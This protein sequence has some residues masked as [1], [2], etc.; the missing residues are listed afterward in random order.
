MSR[1]QRILVAGATR[2]FGE[3]LALAA[4]TAGLPVRALVRNPARAPGALTAAGVELVQGDALVPAEVRAATVGCSHVVHAINVPYP[5]W[6]AVMERA[7]T[8]LVAAAEEAGAELVFPGNVYGLAPRFG[9]PLDEDH[10]HRPVSR[11]GALRVR[12]EARLRAS[13]ESGR[14]RV[15]IVRANDFY[16]PTVRNGGV[17]LLF[18]NALA[19]KRL[20]TFTP[21]DVPH[22]MAYVPDLARA[23]VALMQ[24]EDRPGFDVFHLAGHV[25]ASWRDFLGVLAE[26]AGVPLRFR[27]LPPWMIRLG[28]L[29]DPMIRELGELTYLH[30]HPLLL[31]DAKFRARVPHFRATPLRAAL[32]ETV[33]SYRTERAAS[34]A[35]TPAAAPA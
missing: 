25:T 14:G 8:N 29:F 10:P 12:L 19:G 11:K 35:S 33:A 28:G 17:D 18:A 3:A 5:R 31:D 4:R 13:A 32:E 27:V 16:G 1:V 30:R 23:T 22:E 7:T 15:L 2:G 9:V 20:V 34:D 26:C 6:A 24:L 21:A